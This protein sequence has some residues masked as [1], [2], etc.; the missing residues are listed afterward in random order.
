MSQEYL[1]ML[2]IIPAL[3]LS[4]AKDHPT[5]PLPVKEKVS[6][7]EVS[8]ES[9]SRT[10][11]TFGTV[12]YSSKAD[13]YPSTEGI[14]E[15]VLVE[16]GDAVGKDDILARL[17]KNKLLLERERARS[18]VNSKK[19]LLKLAEEKLRLKRK[20]IEAEL[21]T[22]QNSREELIRK[23]REHRNIESIYIKK[24]RLFEAGGISEE[25]LRELEMALSGAETEL[26]QAEG[27]LSAQQIGFRDSDILEAG[28]SVP[29]NETEKKALFV[30]IN[31]RIQE[32]EREVAQAELDSALTRLNAVEMLLLETNIR[33][34][35]AGI[36]G[37]K[38]FDQGEKVS[39]DTKLFTVFNTERIYI[40]V[41]LSE[42]DLSFVEEGQEAKISFDSIGIETRGRVK[43][44]SPYIDPETK[45]CTIKIE[46][47][48]P[49]R[50]IPP[51]AFA[52]VSIITEPQGLR[53]VLPENCI[54]TDRGGNRYVFLVRAGVLFKKEVKVAYKTRGTLVL[55]G[56]L[57]E[58][59]IVCENPSPH[60]REGQEVEI[61][62][63]EV[64]E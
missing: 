33:S 2:L 13:V 29:E 60:F 48:N 21:I 14:I 17:R 56:G 24:K 5:A 55:S 32:A 42:G 23:E 54:L 27:R 49:E 19:A 57:E 62:Y 63:K 50:V 18:E 1:F 43:F 25:Q 53:T 15:E 4:C 30:I 10:L 7:V 9:V 11:D 38:Y 64:D 34:P 26:I 58:G 36:V 45:T 20:S 46:C 39:P 22:L 40:K 31:S 28:Y 61:Y 3:V 35:I 16:E 12:L 47:E 37:K 52:S 44:I 51:G 6:V 41:E 59:D 8:K